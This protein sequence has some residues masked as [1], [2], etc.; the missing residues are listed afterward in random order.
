MKASIHT[1]T[2]A[3][4]S[5]T[6]HTRRNPNVRQLVSKERTCTVLQNIKLGIKEEGRKD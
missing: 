1:D 5:L 2:T 4:L 6:A 3:G